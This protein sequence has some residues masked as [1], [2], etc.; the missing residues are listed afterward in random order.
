MRISR[1]ILF[2]VLALTVAGSA[3]AGDEAKES[4]VAQGP[5]ALAKPHVAP[6]LT[7]DVEALTMQSDF[8][9]FLAGDCPSAVKSEAL[10]HLWRMM[11]V[12]NDGLDSE[13]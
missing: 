8:S 11:P 3:R 10:R 9:P 13:Y 2:A 4:V 1:P 6:C 12:L 7:Q 5:A